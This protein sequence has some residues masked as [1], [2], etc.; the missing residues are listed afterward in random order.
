VEIRRTFRATNLAK[1]FWPGE[2][3]TKGDLL[4]Y[5]ETI[6][7]WILPYLKDRPVV[8]TRY[9]DGIAGK[10][11]FQKDAPAY[12]PRWIRTEQVY[13][14]DEHRDISFFVLESPEALAY[15]ANLAS[16]PI[17]IWS[18]RFPH[19]ERPDWL[20][21]DVDPKLSTTEQA[22]IV[23]REVAAVLHEVGIRPYIKTSGQMGV[24]IV[25][26]LQPRYSY[27]EARMFSE[28]VACLVLRRVPNAATLI[29]DPAARKG[30]AYIDFTPL[31][32]GKTIAAPFSVRPIPGAPVSAPLNWGELKTTL[33]PEK[34]NIRTIPARMKQMKRDP[35]L[36][37]LTD[38][39]RL[40]AALPR[41]ERLI[42]AAHA[43]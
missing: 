7:S 26:G 1:V 33:Q 43:Q 25:A 35:F 6:A 24:H 12:A 29:R 42:R 37:A 22:V 28:L 27:R 16:I 31:A 36:G 2:G 8:L 13:S 41:L 21:F 9:P 10:S 20:L 30:R 19:L 40:E 5:Y 15:I 34:F 17:H 38:W 39:Q 14:R 32:Q 18:S 23:A 11:F 3:Y 4:H